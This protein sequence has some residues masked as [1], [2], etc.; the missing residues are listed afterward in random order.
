MNISPFALATAIGLLSLHTAAQAGGFIEDSK[1]TLSMR[2]FYINSDYRSGGKATEPSK[3][4]EWGQAFILSY[5]SGFTQGP[6]GFGVDAIGMLGLKLDSG[7]HIGKGSR[8]PGT[9]FPRESDGASTDD[10]SSLGLTAKVRMSRTELRYGTLMPKLPVVNYNDGRLLPQTYQGGQITS[11]EF[12]NLT[13]I[14]GQIEQVKDR[15][16][17]NYE[18]ISIA[19]SK[20]D[21]NQ[22]RYAGA[23]YQLTRNLT[24][25][26]YYGSLDDFYKQHFLGALHSQPLGCGVLKTDLRYFDSR[27]D[28]ANGHEPAYYANGYYDGGK[29]VKGKID[30]RLYSAMFSYSVAGH[31]LGAGYQ[32]SEG[33]SDFPY[34]E[35]GNGK[36]LY[37]I[38]NAQIGK[39]IHAGEDTWHVRYAYDFGNVGV[40]GLNAGVAYWHGD[41]A[42]YQT[43]DRSEWERDLTVSYTVPRGVLKGVGL[44][45]RNAMYR[46]GFP[47]QRDQDETRVIISY[48]IPLL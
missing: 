12:D 48:S 31:T 9:M 47:G 19:G 33:N 13:L 41:N 5:Q 38:T 26:Y 23:D 20:A 10:F 8:Q 35:Q 18:S 6:V 45:V 3:V 39:F 43:G 42:R 25:Q 30:N 2:N 17:S 29:A 1:A 44:T 11:K 22:F 34:L 28:G 46:P 16:S 24:L 21:S 7:S 15:N 14:A 27:S 36:T 32:G 40:Q 4:E 37:T